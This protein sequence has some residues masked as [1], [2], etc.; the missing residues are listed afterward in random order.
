MRRDRFVIPLGL[1]LQQTG[2]FVRS[3]QNVIAFV[4]P[5]GLPLLLLVWGFDLPANLLSCAVRTLY[6]SESPALELVTLS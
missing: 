6:K 3:A 5:L 1:L 2:H 4:I